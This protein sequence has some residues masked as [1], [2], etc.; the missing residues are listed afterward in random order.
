MYLL[1]HSIGNY[2][3]YFVIAYEGKESKK[4]YMYIYKTE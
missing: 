1:L 2:I 4:E 3:Q